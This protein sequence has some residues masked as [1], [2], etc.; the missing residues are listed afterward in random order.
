[1]QQPNSNKFLLIRNLAMILSIL[2]LIMLCL[3]M[4][5]T[6]Q[7]MLSTNSRTVIIDQS[8]NQY[9]KLETNADLNPDLKIV[10]KTIEA[11][12]PNPNPN[13]SNLKDGE[14]KVGYLGIINNFENYK[15]LEC[16]SN[17]PNCNTAL[18]I[19]LNKTGY[20]NLILNKNYILKANITNNYEI[21][22]V[23]LKEE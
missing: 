8:E 9:L 18:V 3:L 7:S 10:L 23:S 1:M 5:V 15:V 17:T 12:K 16:S 13:T 2:G 21:T 19:K 4:I 22:F 6:I 11:P 14:M 20:P